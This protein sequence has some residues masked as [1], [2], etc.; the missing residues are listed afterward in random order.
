MREHH[1]W[2]WNITRITL[3]FL[4]KSHWI[5]GYVKNRKH[6]KTFQNIYHNIYIYIYTIITHCPS[7][8]HPICWWNLIFNPRH[9]AQASGF[10][11]SQREEHV[12][13]TDA[14]A[15]V[16]TWESSPFFLWNSRGME[17]I[18]ASQK[19]LILDRV[20][21]HSCCALG[22]APS[23]LLVLLP[24]Y[25]LLYVLIFASFFLGNCGVLFKRCQLR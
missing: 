16:G 3:L 17:R 4:L 19:L 12:T 23:F 8:S 25:I 5:V 15:D 1:A 10:G 18:F 6:P 7:T 11:S 20:F 2:S 22:F 21:F 13:G 14:D 9:W 24:F